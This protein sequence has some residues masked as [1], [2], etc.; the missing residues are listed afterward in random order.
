[1]LVVGWVRA[2]LWLTIGP[3]GGHMVEVAAYATVA[4]EC[5]C[6]LVAERLRMCTTLAMLIG[7]YANKCIYKCMP[8]TYLA[9]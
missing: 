1:M 9:T 4:G 8:C 5:F 7:I 2:R 3:K 6:G